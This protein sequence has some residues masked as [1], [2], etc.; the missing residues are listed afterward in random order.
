[1]L[2]ETHCRESNIQATNWEVTY[3]KSIADK[4]FLSKMYKNSKPQQKGNKQPNLKMGQQYEQK[5]QQ[6]YIH[7]K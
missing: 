6:R 5:P 7:G 3:A 2:C 4:G 1:M